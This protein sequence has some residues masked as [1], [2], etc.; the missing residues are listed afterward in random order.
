MHNNAPIILKVYDFYKL[1]FEIIKLFPKEEKTTTG[2]EIKNTTLK[3][4]E[5]LIAAEYSPKEL[6]INLL[7]KTSVKLDLLKILIRLPY[8]IKLINQKK[9]IQLEENL[10]EIGK[11]LG[12]WIRSCKNTYSRG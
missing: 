6:K 12:G 10:Q 5:L 4:L 8:D 1:V 9:Y 2:Q 11:M 3:I 7:E